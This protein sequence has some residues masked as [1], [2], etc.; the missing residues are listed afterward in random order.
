MEGAEAAD[1][2][3]GQGDIGIAIGSGTDVAIESADIVLV[4]ND[5]LDIVNAYN[6]SRLTFRTI[7]LNLFWAFFYNCLGVL[8]ACGLFYPLFGIKLNPM[9]ASLAMSLSSVFVVSNALCINFF[10]PIQKTKKQ[11]GEQHSME[12][13]H[14]DIEGMMCEHCQK[15]VE[16]ALLKVEGV[17]RVIISLKQKCADVEGVNLNRTAIINAVNDAGYKAK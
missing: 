12:T 13:I 7:V 11:K 2:G 3:R 8:L 17:S 15:R 9:I 1:E 10:K 14:I 6:L 16:E 5:L 4:H